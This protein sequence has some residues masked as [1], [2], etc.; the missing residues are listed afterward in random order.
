[1]TKSDCYTYRIAFTSASNYTKK[2]KIWECMDADTHEIHYF[3]D[4]GAECTELISYDPQIGNVYKGGGWLETFLGKSIKANSKD[5]DKIQKTVI[6]GAAAIAILAL[7][8]PSVI[9]W[10]KTSK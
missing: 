4:N 10:L 7:L 6:Y 9:N 8:A 2:I 3:L 5:I 1:M